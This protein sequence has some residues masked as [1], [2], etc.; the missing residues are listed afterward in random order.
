MKKERPTAAV[1]VITLRYELDPSVYD[2]RLFF[3]A[4][5]AWYDKI[6]FAYALKHMNT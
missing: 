2:V 4:Q 6:R 3:G 1:L 5:Q